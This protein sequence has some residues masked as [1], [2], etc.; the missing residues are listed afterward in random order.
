[1]AALV[2]WTNHW[3]LFLEVFIRKE[4]RE[5]FALLIICKKVEHSTPTKPVLG[6][7]QD[8]QDE[9][10]RGVSIKWVVCFAPS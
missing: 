9:T 8:F 3:V 7:L 10:R 2:N 1:M 6:E 5:C 4:E